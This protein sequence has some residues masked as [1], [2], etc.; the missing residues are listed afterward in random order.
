MRHWPYREANIGNNEIQFIVNEQIR[1][2]K[3]LNNI[4]IQNYVKIKV[5]TYLYKKSYSKFHSCE[6]N[7]SIFKQIYIAIFFINFTN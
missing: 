6:S 1:L 4:Y 3:I 5:E 7:L 2:V